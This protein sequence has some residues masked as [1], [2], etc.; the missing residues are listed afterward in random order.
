[1]TVE[2]RANQPRISNVVAG[3]ELRARSGHWPRAHLSSAADLNARNVDQS[4]A[5]ADEIEHVRPLTLVRRKMGLMKVRFLELFVLAVTVV[6]VFAATG[7]C[8]AVPSEAPSRLETVG[9]GWKPFDPATD[10]RWIDLFGA[11]DSDDDGP[12]REVVPRLLELNEEL[13][14]YSSTIRNSVASANSD[15]KPRCGSGQRSKVIGRRCAWRGERSPTRTR[16]GSHR[17]MG[18]SRKAS[19]NGTSSWSGR[20]ECGGSSPSPTTR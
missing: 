16:L 4:G 2:L 5:Q 17:P 20:M 12:L 13:L 15:S 14:T 1:L 19:S 8:N 3:I 10:S 9:R 18:G 11:Y 7:H 6:A